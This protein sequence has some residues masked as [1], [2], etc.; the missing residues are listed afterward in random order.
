MLISRFHMVRLKNT[1]DDANGSSPDKIVHSWPSPPSS[2]PFVRSKR[3]VTRKNPL[4]LL[5]VL[6]RETHAFLQSSLFRAAPHFSVPHFFGPRFITGDFVV[7]LT[8]FAVFITVAPT[9]REGAGTFL[10]AGPGPPDALFSSFF[11]RLF[12]DDDSTICSF[13][14]VLLVRFAAPP[15]ENDDESRLDVSE[16]RFL[17]ATLQLRGRNCKR[18]CK[19]KMSTTLS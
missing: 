16:T 9:P 3:A 18:N 10:V 12:F 19:K 2:R 8:A 1:E 6:G 17:H 13:P 14:D 7:F 15:W 5:L 4:P 11:D